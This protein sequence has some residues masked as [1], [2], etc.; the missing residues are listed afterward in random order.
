MDTTILGSIIGA[1]ATI[2]TGFIATF[3]TVIIIIRAKNEIILDSYHKLVEERR[4]IMLYAIDE[5]IIRKYILSTLGFTKIPK[6]KEKLYLLTLLDIDHYQNVYYRAKKKIFPKELFVSWQTSM[7]G[8]FKESLYKEIL[9]SNFRYVMYEDFLDY[10]K[11]DCPDLTSWYLLKLQ[12]KKFLKRLF[13]QRIK[14][15]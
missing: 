11:D 5:P 4:S 7:K 10:V 9:G 2:L 13:G 8:A 15:A 14:T 12:L 6:V 1:A 3:V